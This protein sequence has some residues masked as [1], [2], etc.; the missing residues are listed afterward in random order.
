MNIVEFLFNRYKESIIIPK[1]FKRE[2]KQKYNISDSDIRDLW[3]RINNY[4]IKKYGQ[5]LTT[6]SNILSAEECDR[7]RINAN[8]RIR[9]KIHG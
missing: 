9:K 4:Q 2:I 5:Y 8:Q 3:I 1:N 7:L 6:E